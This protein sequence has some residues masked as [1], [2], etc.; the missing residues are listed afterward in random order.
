[1]GTEPRRVGRYRLLSRIGEG[2]MGEVHHA[3]AY[4]AEGVV[5]DLCVKLIR[6]ERLARPGAAAR[7]VDEARVSMRLHHA[8]IV[9][10][11]DFGRA[12]D[13]YY[14]AMEWV[15]GSDVRS[16]LG[17]LG[18]RGEE[19]APDA[20]AHVVA[21][22]ARAL[23]Y[24]HGLP[25]PVVHCDVKPENVL[26]SV[27][28]DVK[29]ADFGLATVAHEP[30]SGTA[31]TPGYMAPEQQAGGPVGPATDAWA[32]GVLLAEL[33][34]GGRDP[35]TIRDPELSRI[36]RALT[37]ETPDDRP[38]AL[39]AA[40]LLEALVARAR[41]EGSES[42]R[43]RL[44]ELARRARR[45]AREPYERELD[46]VASFVRDGTGEAFMRSMSVLST[47]PPSEPVIA[48]P[49]APARRRVV[50]AALVALAALGVAG[51]SMTGDRLGARAAAGS[52]PAADE[53]P[54]STARASRSAH[55]P[56]ER[57]LPERGDEPAPAAAVERPT[58]TAPLATGSAARR[59]P[60]PSPRRRAPAS[61]ATVEAPAR[62]SLNAVPWG[63]VEIDGAHVGVT[64][65]FDHRLAAGAHRVVFDNPALGARVERTVELAAGEARRLVVDLG[66]AR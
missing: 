66:A 9:A 49:R 33:A 56:D 64:P 36:A 18:R 39:A 54:A 30:A 35:A 4:A 55:P 26:V 23:S 12:D 5:K 6:A 22:V 43:E 60:R 10:V 62:L 37:S 8:N 20:A 31:G 16:L 28:G 2:G 52:T 58:P 48:A 44:A 65:V 46:A 15:E 29:L 41:A 47:V 40:N 38:S 24:S 21:E 34:G 13:A 59:A 27:A 51:Y 3:R 19:L 61:S 17:D 53:A 32:L 45:D 57:S 7:F 50:G 25:E 42:P 1:M 63:N 11:F 14:L